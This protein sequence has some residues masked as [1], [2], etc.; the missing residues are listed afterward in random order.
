MDGM[1]W[2]GMDGMGVMNDDYGRKG[3]KILVTSLHNDNGEVALSGMICFE[4]LFFSF[5]CYDPCVPLE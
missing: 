1:G 3:M 5:P 2:D 4:R